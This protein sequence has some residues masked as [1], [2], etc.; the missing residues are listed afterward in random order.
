MELSCLETSRTRSS[1][2]PA[3]LGREPT[4]GRIDLSDSANTIHLARS[5]SELCGLCVSWIP[6]LFLGE[7]DD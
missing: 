3:G 4:A 6:L 7:Q 2:S 5:K 1:Q